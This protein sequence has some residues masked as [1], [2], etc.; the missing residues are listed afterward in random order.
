M[1]LLSLHDTSLIHSLCSD[2]M[3]FPFMWWCFLALVYLA[4]LTDTIHSC[5]VPTWYWKN[6]IMIYFLFLSTKNGK[7]WCYCRF[8]R[9]LIYR[10][11][12][13]GKHCGTWKSSRRINCSISHHLSDGSIHNFLRHSMTMSC[14]IVSIVCQSIFL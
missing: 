9:L 8:T 10:D 12:Q 5:E 6:T 4:Q 1:Q 13:T 3:C 11:T 2:I 7:L 14:W